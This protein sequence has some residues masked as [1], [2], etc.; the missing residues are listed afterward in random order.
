MEGTAPPNSLVFTRSTPNKRGVS[1]LV[2]LMRAAKPGGVCGDPPNS[3]SPPALEQI[4]PSEQ[5]DHDHA[6]LAARRAQGD[7][8]F[9]KAWA[10]GRTLA[11][12]EA[13]AM[14]RLFRP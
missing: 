12:S 6:I 10:E 11:M 14:A 4:L 7:E 9:A 5:K 2:W 13:L 3:P 1:C 8:A